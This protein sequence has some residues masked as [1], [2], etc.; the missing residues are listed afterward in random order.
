MVDGRER[1]HAGASAGRAAEAARRRRWSGPTASRRRCSG[2]GSGAVSR[3]AVCGGVVRRAGEM[4]QGG[5]G[6]GH[7]AVRAA[8][9]RPAAAAGDDDA[10]ADEADE[11]AAGGAGDG[12]DADDDGGEPRASRGWIPEGDRRALSR[13]GAGAAGARGRA[14]RGSA[15]CAVAARSMFRADDGRSAERIVVAVDP[16]AS[17]G[18]EV[19]CVRDRRRGARRRRGGGAGGPDGAAGGAA[20]V[21]AARGATRSRTWRPTASSPRSTRAATW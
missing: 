3:A 10:A 14:D 21:G 2:S 16:P 6:L 15:G 7:A 8:A 19:G 17:S 20:E 13:H 4:D 1:H 12:G 9:G 18:R 5:R 11:A